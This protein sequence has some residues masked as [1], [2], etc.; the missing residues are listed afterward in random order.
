MAEQGG[1]TLDPTVP[2][3]VQPDGVERWKLCVA[4]ARQWTGQDDQAMETREFAR[5]LYDSSVP[6]S[7][8]LAEGFEENLHPRRRDGEFRRKPQIVRP[9]ASSE[10]K[11][12]LEQIEALGLNR[13]PQPSASTKKVLGDHVDTA[14]M[15]SVKRKATAGDS[16]AHAPYK[17]ARRGL[18]DKIVGSR[19]GSAV[20]SLLGDHHPLT[21]KLKAGDRLSDED[22]QTIRD[23]ADA[24]REDD[25]SQSP[26]ALFM[27]GGPASGKSTVLEHNPGL[28]PTHSVAIDCDSL[29]L[30]L[31]E[32]QQ[33][34]VAGDRYAASAV[35]TESG[36]I[37]ARLAHEAGDL[38][39]NVVIDGTGNSER[40]AFTRDLLKQH[41]KGYD[42]SVIYATTSTD[43][44]VRRAVDRA[45]ATGRFVPVPAVRE[46]HAK[47]SANFQDIV[48]LDWLVSLDV[49][50]ETGHIGE[51][52][53]EGD[54][55][56]IDGGAMNAFRAKA[57]ERA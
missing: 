45:E 55:Y 9:V 12:S 52:T 29:K 15:W 38:R 4:A 2:A 35:H 32:Y 50:N 20:G 18:H 56:D 27:A 44:A 34:R 22:K 3:D 36:D 8:E 26:D 41:E 11:V 23:A 49:Y 7:D 16:P 40:G 10:P 19:L 6:T 46:Q 14:A 1:T 57:D 47:V 54:F 5:R 53:E 17:V 25:D 28:K 51:M 33:L 31:P 37:A 42:V 30:D 48:N 39:L 21:I 13:W 43:T 24:A